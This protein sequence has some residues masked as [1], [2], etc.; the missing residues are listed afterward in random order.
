[1]LRQSNL[2]GQRGRIDHEQACIRIMSTDGLCEPGRN[3]GNG[4]IGCIVITEIDTEDLNVLRGGFERG[5]MESGFSG[6]SCKKS[7]AAMSEWK[8]LGYGRWT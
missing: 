3:R 1:M 6:G 5:E 7:E 4:V 8:S 2:W